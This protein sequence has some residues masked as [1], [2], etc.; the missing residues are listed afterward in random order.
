[1]LPG[2]LHRWSFS[3]LLCSLFNN[4]NRSGSR[5]GGGVHCRGLSVCH[6]SSEL[7]RLLESEDDQGG[8]GQSGGGRD[9]LEVQ[10]RLEALVKPRAGPRL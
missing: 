5:A 6:S 9:L 10:V 4:S 1:M 2:M 3:L 7:A 8:V